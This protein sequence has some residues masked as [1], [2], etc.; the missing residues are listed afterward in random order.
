MRRHRDLGTICQ[1][2]IGLV[3]KLFNARK[4]V[5]PTAAIETSGVF[6]QLVKNLIHLERRWDGFD[7]DR[8]ANRPLRYPEFV[9]RHFEHVVP[10]TRLQMAFH[11]RQ[12]KIGPAAPRE[13]IRWNRGARPVALADRFW[14][15]QKIEGFAAVERRLSILPALQTF[16]PTIAESALQLCHE[17]KRIRAN[18]FRKR[19]RKS[20]AQ[21]DAW[22]SWDRGTVHR[23]VILADSNRHA[24]LVR[25][26]ARAGAQPLTP[27]PASVRQSR[28]KSDT[29]A[30]ASC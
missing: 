19:R 7:E 17:G 11:F 5:I 29:A 3:S 2:K 23:L 21:L 20:A 16:F 9:L 4:N 12:I 6:P 10:K 30:G 1:G 25:N 18:D 8:R 28:K 14:F 22:R 13:H 27:S 26:T 15:R 24:R